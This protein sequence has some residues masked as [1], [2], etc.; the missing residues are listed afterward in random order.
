[1]ALKY[2][3]ATVA[4]VEQLEETDLDGET[5]PPTPDTATYNQEQGRDDGAS[6]R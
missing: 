1:M 4:P 3:S 5:E 2:N 6:L